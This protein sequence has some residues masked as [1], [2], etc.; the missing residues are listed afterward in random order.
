MNAHPVKCLF[1]GRNDWAQ[2]AHLVSASLREVGCWSRVIVESEHKYGYEYPDVV[3]GSSWV[4]ILD[5]FASGGTNCRRWVFSC[6]GDLSFFNLYCSRLDR[7][8][9]RF[10]KGMLHIG[11]N[12]R[13]NH[14]K[15]NYADRN[16]GVSLRFV[17]PD[18]MHL[19]GSMHSVSH[20]YAHVCPMTPIEFEPVGESRPVVV[21]S[22]SRRLYKGTSKIENAL[23]LIS[24][25]SFEFRVIEGLPWKD[26][27]EARSGGHI[28]IGQFNPALGGF[29]YSSVEACAQGMVPICSM[30]QGINNRPRLWSFYGLEPPPIV[31]VDTIN[32]LVK[33]V[34]SLL[35]DKAKLDELRLSSLEWVKS[36]SASLS[37]AGEYYLSK[38]S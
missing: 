9:C 28:F 1:V 21:H 19:C 13:S 4:E 3:I 35:S 24:T 31:H 25:R 12:F 37:R 32:D 7:I 11:S 17:S 18:S 20:P 6:D 5:E 23:S 36:G 15:I 22:P 16:L 30:H 10:Y 34:E 33:T 8:G 14:R 38:M 29:G 2:C 26:C 27:V